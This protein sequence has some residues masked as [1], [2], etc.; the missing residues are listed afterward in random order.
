M[1]LIVAGAACKLGRDG[2]GGGADEGQLES[3]ESLGSIDRLPGGTPVSIDV[4]TLMSARCENGTLILRTNREEITSPMD[5]GQ[6][7][8][9]SIVARFIS[10]P[11]AIR[12]QDGRLVVESA[13]KGTL[14]FPAAEPRIEEISGAP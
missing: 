2:D 7:L 10:E 3:G 4:R 13:T 1:S 9:E 8:P 14:D 12:A 11:V 5:C 6:M